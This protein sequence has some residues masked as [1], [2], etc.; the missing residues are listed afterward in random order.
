[1]KNISVQKLAFTGLIAA[2]YAALTMALAPISYGA[3]QFRISECLCI[4]PFFFPCT[5]WGLFAGCLLAN[6]ISQFGIADIVFGSLATLLAGLCTA[7]IGRKGRESWLRCIAACLMPVLFNALI[8][9]AVIAFCSVEEF[10]SAP[11]LAIFALNALEVGFGELVVLF[12]VG[13]PLTRVLPRQ[14]FFRKL[15]EKLN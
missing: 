9:G 11:A 14:P 7:A 12:V 4:L 5:A 6:L 3:I 1:M 13:L 10:W 8:V 2:V 15:G